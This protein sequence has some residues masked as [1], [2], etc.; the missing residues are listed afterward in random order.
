MAIRE[1][2]VSRRTLFF[3]AGLVWLIGG[4]VLA[5]RMVL[6]FPESQS[7]WPIYIGA[8]LGVIKFILA[9]RRVAE[10]NIRRIRDLSPHKDKICVFAFQS[11]SS[12]L[13]VLVMI[14]LGI[15]LR[16]VGVPPLILSLVYAMIAMALVLGSIIYF[17]ALRESEKVDSRK[18]P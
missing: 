16:L 14:G 15:G 17:R 8:A 3:S 11:W 7:L 10:R 2:A 12:Y 9:F 13:L 1:P 5:W 6:V 4:A 18:L